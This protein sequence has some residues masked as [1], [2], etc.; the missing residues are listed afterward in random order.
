MSMKLMSRLCKMGMLVSA[1]PEGGRN[2]AK[3]R[4]DHMHVVGD[5]QLNRDGQE[6][7]MS[8]GLQYW[9]C[10]SFGAAAFILRRLIWLEADRF[11]HG[12]TFGV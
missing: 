10:R 11:C 2:V 12:R 7:R 9:L 4:F 5:T 1:P 8:F 3:N 6:Q